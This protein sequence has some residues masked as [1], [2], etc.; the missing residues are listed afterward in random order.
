[1]DLK[2]LSSDDF[3]RLKQASELAALL[4]PGVDGVSISNRQFIS[5]VVNALIADV[6]KNYESDLDRKWEEEKTREIW[7]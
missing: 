2:L 3:L 1:M 5:N 4:V 7:D 6:K